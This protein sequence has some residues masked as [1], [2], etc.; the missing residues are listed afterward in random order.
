MSLIQ[1]IL[2]NSDVFC[3]AD[4]SFILVSIDLL[5]STPEITISSIKNW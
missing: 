2:E 1:Q 5:K 4:Y 3:F